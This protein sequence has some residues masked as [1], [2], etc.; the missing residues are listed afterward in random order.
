MH[1]NIAPNNF[2]TQKKYIIIQNVLNA[3]TLLHNITK[4]QRF[5]IVL[6]GGE[7]VLLAIN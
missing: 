2:K 5:R 7:C 1:Q 3:R 4:I 6:Q